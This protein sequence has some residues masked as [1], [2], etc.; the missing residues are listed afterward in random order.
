MA[1]QATAA[2]PTQWASQYETIY[3]LRPNVDPDEAEKVA[4]RVKE[5]MDRLNATIVKVDNW[6]KRKLAYLIKKHSRGIFIYVNYVAFNDVVAELERTL[7]L[8][9]PVM[10]Y[11]TIVLE[12]MIDPAK[13]EVDAEETE[14]APIEQTEEEPELNQAQR[15]GLAPIERPA[16]PAPAAAEGDAPAAAEGLHGGGHVISRGELLF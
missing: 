6:G 11:Q 5:V 15:L 13:V 14:F 10:R 4:N 7:R 16:P 8:L 12:K 1:N 9:E 2:E 3:I